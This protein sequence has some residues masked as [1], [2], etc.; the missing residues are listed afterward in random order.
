MCASKT[1][2]EL[3]IHIPFCIKKC[4]YC[5]FL[6]FPSNEERR[7]IYVQSLINE[8]E[9]TGKLLDKDAL[10][11][12]YSFVMLLRLLK[13]LNP[14]EVYCAGTDGYA[15]TGS[16][17]ADEDMEYWFTSRKADVLNQYVRDALHGM[18][19]DFKISFLTPSYYEENL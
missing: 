7:E 4:N 18:E 2:L 6:S 19:N 13:D 16:N 5:D 9:Q 3:Y 15:T 8:I 11:I 17:Y 1:D 10:V 12:D 14:S